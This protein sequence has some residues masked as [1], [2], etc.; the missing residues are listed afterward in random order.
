MLP[1]KSVIVIL[2]ISLIFTTTTVL[3]SSYQFGGEVSTGL[4]SIFFEDTNDNNIYE[5]INLNLDFNNAN[6]EISANNNNLKN[7]FQINLKKAYVRHKFKGTRVTLG[8]QP[9]SWSFG[10][11]INPVDYSLGAEALDEETSAKYVDAIEFHY[12][13]NWYSNVSL[14][15]E[16]NN[17]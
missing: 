14:V 6:F 2:T 3:A 1:K 13:I 12:P 4:N 16:Y 8:K 5:T 15:T 11:L 7:D 17:N 9:I 10:S